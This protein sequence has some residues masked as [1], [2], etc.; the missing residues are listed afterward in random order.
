MANEI[1]RLEFCKP[2]LKLN[3]KLSVASPL[4]IVSPL[5]LASTNC[6]PVYS[7]RQIT[8][9][10]ILS[11]VNQNTGSYQGSLFESANDAD[12]SEANPNYSAYIAALA[13]STPISGS[14]A[15]PYPADFISYQFY[16]QINGDT[17]YQET[18]PNLP[19][20]PFTQSPVGFGQDMRP[21]PTILLGGGAEYNGDIGT[22]KPYKEYRQ[23]FRASYCPNQ[24]LTVWYDTG[25]AQ[26]KSE[27]S[28]NGHSFSISVQDP[29]GPPPYTTYSI[30]V[31]LW[32]V[33]PSLTTFSGTE[34]TPSLI[35]N[36]IRQQEPPGFTRR[37]GLMNFGNATMPGWGGSTTATYAISPVRP[38]LV[39]YCTSD[40]SSISLNSVGG[41]AFSGSVSDVEVTYFA[42]PNSY[43]FPNSYSWGFSPLTTSFTFSAVVGG[44]TLT[45]A[46]LVFGDPSTP[47]YYE[48]LA[49]A[50]IVFTP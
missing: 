40:V 36:N 7:H 20:P 16:Y 31:T 46:T 9:D 6:N 15:Y 32:E 25:D 48:A 37:Y 17:A 47:R 29:L 13:G 26:L 12:T 43:N 19:S 33:R 14:A 42:T 49:I 38:W 4:D 3:K 28:G 41:S 45:P 34:I 21:L 18:F 5:G 2:P 23:T 35:T 30:N 8:G 50:S 44:H 22:R 27:D 24:P 39:A 1:N 10:T 11:R